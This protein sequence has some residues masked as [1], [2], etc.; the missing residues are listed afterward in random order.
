MQRKKVNILKEIREYEIILLI[1]VIVSSGINLSLALK[2]CE[3][4]NSKNELYKKLN[5]KIL[6]GENYANN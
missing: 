2:Y 5:E 3:E 4:E 6:K 1:K